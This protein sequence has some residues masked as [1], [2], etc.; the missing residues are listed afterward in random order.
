MLHHRL[1]ASREETAAPIHPSRVSVSDVIERVELEAAAE[2]QA[3]GFGLAVAP[4]P[5]GVYVEADPQVLAAAVTKLVH[6]AFKHSRTH[7][8]VSLTT[9][10]TAEHVLI[11]V[12]DECGGLRPGEAEELLRPVEEKDVHRPHPGL[13][14]A[15]SL[16][17]VEV[18][19]GQIRLRELPGKGCAFTV[20]L[21][22][23]EP[24]ATS[25]VRSAVCPG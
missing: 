23:Q 3:G 5:R 11:E 21:P 18:M 19:G 24:P 15:I 22:R 6:N 13:G 20:D 1:T 4:A 14:L 16:R 9:T 12:E 10:A 8:H 7:G 25:R 2:A 17:S